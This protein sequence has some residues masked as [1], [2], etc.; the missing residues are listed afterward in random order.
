[1]VKATFPPNPNVCQA[2]QPHDLSAAYPGTLEVGRQPNGGLY[3]ITELTFPQYLKGIAEVPTSW[4][5]QALEAQVV[6][7]RTYAISHMNAGGAQARALDYNLCSTDACQVYR[8]LQSGNGT[9]A[10]DPNW[11]RAVDDTAGQILEYQGKPIDAFY[12][13]TSNGHT[14]SSADI[15]GGSAVP[16]LQPVTESDDTSS[17]TSNWSVRMPLGD[18]AE[19]LRLSGSWGSE[20]IETVAQEGDTIQVAGGG[21]SASMALSSFR[22]RLNIQG[23]CLTPQRYPTPATGGGNLPQVV[24]SV[25]MTLRQD[26]AAIVMTGRGWGHGV[27]MVQYGAKGKADRGLTY[28]KILAYYYGGLTPV[29][30]AEPGSIRVLLATGVQQ[31]T[32]APSGP[33][34]VDG[35]P[36]A[37]GTVT[38][39]GGSSMTVASSAQSPVTPTLTLSGVTVTATA[40][41]G[42]P[43]GFSFNLNHAANV[44]ITYQ[45]SG[46]TA[47]ASVAPVPVAAGDQTL[48]W[49]PFAAGLPLGTYDVALVADDGVSRVVSPSFQVVV[50]NP[51][52]T[53]SPS[54][55]KLSA[56]GSHGVKTKVPPWVPVGVGAVLLVFLLLAGAGIAAKR[57]KP[58]PRP[59]GPPNFVAR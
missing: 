52:P 16:Y 53:P 40:M 44:G 8:G 36:G 33:V 31:V 6:A 3:L 46:V 21:K 58:P 57:R 12:F 2:N 29:R 30:V 22:N 35:A 18:L 25:W 45:Q 19:I 14:Y 48:Q 9:Y 24:P 17:P 26:G 23:T 1:M 11:A 37:S 59:P 38:I 47:T 5:Q 28:A 20:P 41:P 27:G 51:P 4:P 43:A 49:D 55:S 56:G 10:Q 54:P 42:K 13:S 34:R 15:F 50:A 39:T 7:A 32:V